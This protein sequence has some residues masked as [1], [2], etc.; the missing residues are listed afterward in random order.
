MSGKLQPVSPLISGGLVWLLVSIL[1][2]SLS[3][4]KKN[5]YPKPKAFPRLTYESSG[6]ISEKLNDARIQFQ[7]PAATNLISIN[8]KKSGVYWYNLPFTK[9]QAV[10][11]LSILHLKSGHF[12]TYLTEKEQMVQKQTPPLSSIT[13][14]TFQPKDNRLTGYIY[15]IHGDA[16]AP[17]HFFIHDHSGNLCSGS[18]VFDNLVN[19]DSISEILS[20]MK[21]D[22]CHLMETFYFTP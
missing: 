9:Y 1:I 5:E 18:L 7:R 17:I 20:G 4:C 11:H 19:S 22:I 6:Y 13:K 16:P 2:L 14:T 10:L 15:T 21:R 12:E 8:S 3:S